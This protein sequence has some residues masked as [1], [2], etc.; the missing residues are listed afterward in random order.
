MASSTSPA[1][2]L[3][4]SNL[5]PRRTVL[6]TSPE[7]TEVQQQLGLYFQILDAHSY[8]DMDPFK[9]WTQQRQAS[10]VLYEMAISYLAIPATTASVERVFS[11]AGLAYDGKRY[12]TQEQ[13]LRAKISLKYNNL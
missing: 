10:A 12:R 3:P 11:V 5:V 1:V 9:F 2:H 8:A 13:F 4:F 6:H 7:L